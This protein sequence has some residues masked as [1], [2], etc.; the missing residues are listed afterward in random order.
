[1]WMSLAYLAS[2]VKRLAGER[3]SWL[4]RGCMLGRMTDALQHLTDLDPDDPRTE[5]QQIANKLRAAILTR[6]LQPGEKLPSQPE[7][8]SRYGVAR[9]TVKAALRVLTN[10]RL[11]ISRQGSGTFVR[12]Q[13]ER[14]VGLRPH[15][16]AAFESAHVA[17]DFAGFGAETLRNTLSEVLDKVR[18]GRLTPESIAVR[19]M[20]SD[21]AVPMALPCRADTASD[22]PAIRKRQGR[23]TRR[24][25]ESIVDDVEELADLGLVK[26]ATAQVR[27]HGAAP[28]FKL[29]ILNNEEAF[30]GFYPVV[31]HDVTIDGEAV[32]IFDPMGKD[33]TLFQYSIS[34]EDD[35]STAAEYVM[36]ARTWFDSLWNTISREYARD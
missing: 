15:V 23:I 1:M 34:A 27:I 30:F 20:V 3:L 29:Y 10:E 8:A 4:V 12:A 21:M 32:S 36:Q 2:H 28:L 25:I 31:Q 17:I 5:S 11:I 24:A 22:D 16:E 19:I 26:S 18:A 35:T 14:P 9:E 6:K 13:T 33:A 7:L